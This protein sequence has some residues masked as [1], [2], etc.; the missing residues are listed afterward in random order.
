M[1]PGYQ[2]T[3]SEYQLIGWCYSGSSGH[4]QEVVSLSLRVS[5]YSLDQERED[6]IMFVEREGLN[7]FLDCLDYFP[8][9][10]LHI[11]PST[12]FA[13]C[14]FVGHGVL[15]PMAPTS[16]SSDAFYHSPLHPLRQIDVEKRTIPRDF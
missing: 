12:M 11:D 10:F 13:R 9:F 8:A 6:E 2:I 16:R 4:I 3:V 15:Y 5:I 14:F 1:R 7:K